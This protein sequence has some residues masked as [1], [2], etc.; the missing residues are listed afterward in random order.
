MQICNKW[1]N[2]HHIFP[3]KHYFRY[4]V[5]H[6]HGSDN[7]MAILNPGF[8]F[9]VLLIAVLCCFLLAV[10]SP[11]QKAD[12]RYQTID[13]LRGYLALFVF[14]HHAS[15][16]HLFMATGE[17]TVPDSNLY[18]HLGQISVTFFFMITGF[19]FYGKLLGKDAKAIDWPKFFVARTLRLGPLYV[20]AMIALMTLVFLQSG[21]N[22]VDSPGY[23]LRSIAR[24][25]LFTI[26]GAPSVNGVYAPMLIAGVNWSLPYE[27]Y[28]YLA[29]PLLAFVRRIQVPWP[30]MLAGVAMMTFAFANGASTVFMSIFGG[31]IAA[32]YAVRN[33]AFVS[34]ARS[35]VASLLVMVLVGTV[36]IL[37]DTAYQYP[38][39]IILA[40]AFSLIAGG[41]DLFGALRARPSHVLGELSYSIY[42][43]HGMLLFVTF[44]Y[45][46][47]YEVARS[48]SAVSYWAVVGAV[49]PALLI[50]SK[51]AFHAIE[52]P[53]MRIVPL[54]MAMLR[55]QKLGLGRIKADDPLIDRANEDRGG[56]AF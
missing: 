13:G 24:W 3:I 52:L 18:T 43:L 21:A 41:A 42:L 6:I 47:G 35:K 28:F 15:V 12:S 19:L 7:G 54:V 34:F 20:A 44:K 32:A 17:W 2:G 10:V 8:S 31:G 36:V 40:V 55:A 22:L 51:L 45:V 49:V 26:P 46:T 37:F 14:I 23:I 16:W 5:E 56:P 27:W 50:I 11:P 39:L 53:S 9:G 33:A 30:F 1:S 38:P 29:V 25:M 48:M 4:H